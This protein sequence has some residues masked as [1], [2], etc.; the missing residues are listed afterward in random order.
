[1]KKINLT[2][3]SLIVFAALVC[4]SGVAGVASAGV[5]DPDDSWTSEDI[6]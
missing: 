5:T 3:V 1:M 2:S 6:V 4:A